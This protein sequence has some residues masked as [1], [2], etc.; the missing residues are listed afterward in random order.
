MANDNKFKPDS[1]NGFP[2]RFIIFLVAAVVIMFVIQTFTSDNYAKVSFS[3][4]VEHL[5]N[6]DLTVP[7]EN[8]KIAQSENL[9]TFSGKFRD[10][11]SEESRDRYHY[12]ELLNRHHQMTMN[13]NLL[14]Q[15]LDS[16]K[17]MF[18]NPQS[19]FFS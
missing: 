11:A 14:L 16:L 9:V 3:H 8:R 17:K 12:L 15:D 19:C 18:A 13:Q 1:K 10:A 6:L 5:I 7:E 4:Q 2:G